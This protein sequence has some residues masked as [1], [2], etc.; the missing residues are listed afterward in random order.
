VDIG[1]P[2]AD[3]NYPLPSS[4]FR[5][6][7]LME[8]AGYAG[9]RTMWEKPLSDDWLPTSDSHERKGQSDVQIVAGELEKTVE[10]CKKALSLLS[11]NNLLERSPFD[12]DDVDEG[13]EYSN[14]ASQQGVIDCVSEISR[15]LVL[16]SRLCDEKSRSQVIQIREALGLCRYGIYLRINLEPT[17][18]RIL[19]IQ[20]DP[21]KKRF[22]FPKKPLGLLGLD[23]SI[24]VRQ[25]SPEEYWDAMLAQ[26]RKHARE[27]LPQIRASLSGGQPIVMPTEP[28]IW[29]ALAIHSLFW[30]GSD[31]PVSLEYILA[32]ADFINVGGPKVNEL[33][34]G[35]WQLKKR[36][37]LVEREDGYALTKEGLNSVEA[38]IGQYSLKDG[39]KLLRTWIESHSA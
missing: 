19:G 4:I 30:Q 7:E 13:R 28:V 9:H 31:S 14:K 38:I 6:Q 15:S 25:W 24:E 20:I 11:Q 34:W 35:L 37:W 27:M 22:G 16:I 33:A 18:K 29:E 12:L 5:I 10:A 36:N 3:E 1:S 39:F 21:P 23:K 17:L 26:Y 2:P 8:V 32:S